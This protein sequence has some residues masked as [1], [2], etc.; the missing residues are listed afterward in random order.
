MDVSCV[1]AKLPP[2]EKVNP[3]PPASPVRYFFPFYLINAGTDRNSS[4][5]ADLCW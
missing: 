2:E 4:A 5:L 1:A 3:H